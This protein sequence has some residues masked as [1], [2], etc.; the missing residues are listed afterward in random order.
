MPLPGRS[1]SCDTGAREEPYTGGQSLKPGVTACIS[2][3]CI[4]SGQAANRLTVTNVGGGGKTGEAST[5]TAGAY[6]NAIDTF[7]TGP[8]SDFADWPT[9]TTVTVNASVTGGC[10]GHITISG[11]CSASGS[12]SVSCQVVLNS[13]KTVNVSF[14]P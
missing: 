13:D 5:S 10:C 7:T 11:G 4:P 3:Q 8:T 12:N 2:T 14:S 6:P 9:N 1:Q